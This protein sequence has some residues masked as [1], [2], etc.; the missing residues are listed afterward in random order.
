MNSPLLNDNNLQDLKSSG[1]NDDI[2]LL[3]KC[4]SGSAK[5]TREILGFDVGPGLIIPYTEILMTNGTPYCQVKPD[6]PPI[7][8][9]RPAKYQTPKGEGNH[10]YIPPNLAPNILTYTSI[11]LLLTEG[12]KKALK[13][14]QE[15]FPTI[16]LSGV[17][18]EPNSLVYLRTLFP[19]WK[20]S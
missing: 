18:R 4:F 8:D 17:S 20:P 2:I 1:L 12:V 9:G 6:K 10:I 11:P 7:I 19:R 3:S 15:G 13:A 5:K 16:A 14:C